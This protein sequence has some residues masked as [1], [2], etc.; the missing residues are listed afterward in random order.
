[1]TRE[2]DPVEIPAEIT[3]A[4]DG[5]YYVKYTVEKECD[6]DIKV[7]CENN[8]GIWKTVRGSPYTASFSA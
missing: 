2:D 4:N 7:A 1:M 6:V 3:D 8:K 5:K